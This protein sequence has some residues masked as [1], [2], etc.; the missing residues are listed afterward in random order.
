MCT[1]TE[2]KPVRLKGNKAYELYNIAV[3]TEKSY[4]VHGPISSAAVAYRH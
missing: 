2:K 4:I 3:T 1:F